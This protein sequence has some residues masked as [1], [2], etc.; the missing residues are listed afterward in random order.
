MQSSVRLDWLTFQGSL[1]VDDFTRFIN[2]LQI[3]LQD[4]FTDSPGA[5]GRCGVLYQSHMVG[6]GRGTYIAYSLQEYDLLGDILD[7]PSIDFAIQLK[8]A[9]L[10]I[11]PCLSDQIHFL[12]Q[13][14]LLFGDLAR[15]SCSRFDIAIDDWSCGCAGV[16]QGDLT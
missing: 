1:S 16:D 13:L 5:G 9:S 11:F 7:D 12:G 6:V 4:S 10:G 15:F 3:S 8:G 14:F 2:Y